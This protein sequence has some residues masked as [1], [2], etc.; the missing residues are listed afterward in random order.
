[1]TKKIFERN[2]SIALVNSADY[3]R[4]SHRATDQIRTEKNGKGC[5]IRR[6]GIH[7]YALEYNGRT[8]IRTAPED[9]LRA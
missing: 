1:M 5:V 2:N 8:N 3:N 7:S 9:S 4:W 6:V